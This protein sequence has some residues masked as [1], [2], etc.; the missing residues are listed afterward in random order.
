M[1][2]ATLP[3]ITALSLLVGSA[4]AQPNPCDLVAP[5]GVDAQD[6]QAAINMALAVAAGNQSACTTNIGGGAICNV[7]VVQRV[8]NA[9]LPGGTCNA[10]TGVVPHS[11]TLTW[12]ASA[13]SGLSGYRIYRAPTAGGP[14][15][16]LHSTPVTGTTYVDYTVIGGVTYYYVARAVASSGTESSNSNEAPAAIATP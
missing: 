7:A 10:G 12:T 13:S 15:T 9:S 14:Y 11:V 5:A 4:A 6:V 8:I 2:K 3:I 16:A 1:W